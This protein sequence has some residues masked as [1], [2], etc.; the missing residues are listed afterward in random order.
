MDASVL[1][2]RDALSGSFGEDFDFIVLEFRSKGQPGA[3]SIVS[4]VDTRDYSDTVFSTSTAL[5]VSA[6][7]EI[8]ARE[9]IFLSDRRY[10]YARV[11]DSTGRGEFNAVINRESENLRETFLDFIKS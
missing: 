4:R 2:P 10:C 8:F 9:I 7:F 11:I 5:A 3:V 1:R 6:S